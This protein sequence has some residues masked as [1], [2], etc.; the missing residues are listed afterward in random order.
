MDSLTLCLQFCS[1]RFPFF[2]ILKNEIVQRPFFLPRFTRVIT[3]DRRM[4]YIIPF[5]WASYC[6]CCYPRVSFAESRSW[7]IIWSY[8]PERSAI[9]PRTSCAK[10]CFSLILPKREAPVVIELLARIRND[11][12]EI[13]PQVLFVDGNETLHPRKYG[14]ACH[15]GVESNTP[16]IGL[17]PH[18]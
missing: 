17:N 11:G 16:T 12:P 3:M 4:R 6:L 1:M 18:H 5:R 14:L 2:G 8:R 7:T 13:Y 9:Y 10:V 15:I